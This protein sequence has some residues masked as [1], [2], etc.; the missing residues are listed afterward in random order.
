MSISSLLLLWRCLCLLFFTCISFF[1]KRLYSLKLFNVVALTQHFSLMIILVSFV[2][3]TIRWYAKWYVLYKL[4][5][6]LPLCV[7]DIVH[8]FNLLLSHSSGSVSVISLAKNYF[9]VF[10][11][12][13]CILKGYSSISELLWLCLLQSESKFFML[14]LRNKFSIENFWTCVLIHG[15]LKE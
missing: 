5:A 8:I 10:L 2:Y 6:V 3:K 15:F 13:V 7:E 14:Q 11:Q 1:T 12:H 4:L 9:Y